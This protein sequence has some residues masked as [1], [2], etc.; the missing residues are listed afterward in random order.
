MRDEL[1][2]CAPR[3]FA[4]LYPLRVH[5]T[6]LPQA[7]A[8]LSQVGEGGEGGGGHARGGGAGGA[9]SSCGGC[10]EEEVAFRIAFHSA[11]II[12]P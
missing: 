11:K 1:D 12:E 9:L 7:L 4:V 10:G 3:V 6:N 5:I 8:E 2:G